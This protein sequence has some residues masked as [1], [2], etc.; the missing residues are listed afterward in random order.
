MTKDFT[1]TVGAI[2]L[3]SGDNGD[4]WEAAIITKVWQTDDDQLVNLT[5]FGD[6]GGT[7]FRSS[8]PVEGHGAPAIWKPLT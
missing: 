2:V 1:P 8:I 3:F 5:V 4:S 7:T 6:Q